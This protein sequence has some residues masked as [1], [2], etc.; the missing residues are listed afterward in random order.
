M[1][2]QRDPED[3]ETTALFDI[4]N[5]AKQNVLE[6]GCGDGR[7]TWLYCDNATH[8][9]AIDPDPDDIAIA[10]EERPPRLRERVDFLVRSLEDF[11]LPEASPRFDIV[12]MSWSL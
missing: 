6:V 11:T 8:V 3:N 12:I 5:F 10:L 7:L 2:I 9:T 4:V 1:A